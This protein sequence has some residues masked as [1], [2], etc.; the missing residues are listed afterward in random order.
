MTLEQL[1]D[2]DLAMSARAEVLARLNLPSTADPEVIR[3]L[4]RLVDQN[5]RDRSKNWSQ[6]LDS[7]AVYH[8]RVFSALQLAVDGMGLTKG[9]P[10]MWPS[11][12]Q[13]LVDDCMAFVA[14]HRRRTLWGVA[15]PTYMIPARDRS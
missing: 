11:A 2:A 12:W 7:D 3:E 1:R 8:A 15:L 14:A 6:P 5:E 13:P 9:A 10:S 4:D